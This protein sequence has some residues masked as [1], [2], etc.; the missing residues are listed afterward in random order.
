MATQ[1]VQMQDEK[2]QLCIL[3]AVTAIGAGDGYTGLSRTGRTYQ[4]SMTGSGAVSATVLVQVSNDNVN[5]MTLGTITL[6]GTGSATDGFAA[7]NSWLY[8]RGNVTAISGT[9]AAVTLCMGV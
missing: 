9:S 3:N 6:S 8:T 2:V 5:W 1:D 4:A 7:D